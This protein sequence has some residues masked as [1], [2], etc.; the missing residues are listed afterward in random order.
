M[1]DTPQKRDRN[2]RKLEKRKE[3]EARKRDREQAKR[4]RPPGT[5]AA[6]I[7]DPSS[8]I[9]DSTVHSPLGGQP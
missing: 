5:Q 9:V 2:R 6:P 4:E 8:T 3:K 7:E 1:V